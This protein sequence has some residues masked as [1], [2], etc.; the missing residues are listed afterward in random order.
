MVEVTLS[1][2]SSG[3]IP[4]EDEGDAS[5]VLDEPSKVVRIHREEREYSAAGFYFFFFPAT[6]FTCVM[7]GLFIENPEPLKLVTFVSLSV[8]WVTAGYVYMLVGVRPPGSI[9]LAWDSISEYWGE[10]LETKITLD[11]SVEVDIL[12]KRDISDPTYGHLY[13]YRFTRGT[14]VTE[15]TAG[16]GWQLW[17]IQNMRRPVFEL[18]DLHRMRQG[19]EMVGYRKLLASRTPRADARDP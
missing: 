12:L 6:F 13:G 15:F 17:D 10:E 2:A 19:D 5:P 7:I 14:D 4:I 8:L 9:E 1:D 18:V 11:P 16:D 3:M